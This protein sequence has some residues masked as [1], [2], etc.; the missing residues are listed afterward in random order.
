MSFYADARTQSA[1]RLQHLIHVPTTSPKMRIARISLACAC[2]LAGAACDRLG[3]DTSPTQPSGP[4]TAGSTINYSV[5]GAS[6]AIGHGSSKPCV[7]YDDCDGTGYVW[8]VA[9]TLRSQ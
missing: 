7:L 8:V 3:G 6:D 4:P 5:V 9:R 2:F 1:S